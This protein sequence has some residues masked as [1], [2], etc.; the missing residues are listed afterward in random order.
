MYPKISI[1]LLAPNFPAAYFYREKKCLDF[2]VL[3]PKLK[4]TCANGQRVVNKNHHVCARDCM[5]SAS[6]QETQRRKAETWLYTGGE[7]F[8]GNGMR[9][10]LGENPLVR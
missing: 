7:S 10:L 1:V 9:I 5:R 8:Y 2:F 6:A 4:I 3:P